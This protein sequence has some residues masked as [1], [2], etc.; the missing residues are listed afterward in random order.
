MLVLEYKVKPK[1]QQVAAI[2]EAIRTSQFVRNKVLRFW[3]DN[4]GVGKAEL[5]RY[6]TA[7]RNEFEFVKDL[8]SHAC[9]TAVERTLRAITRFYENCKQQKLGKKGY[10]KF[11]KHSRSV[12]YKVSGWKLDESTKKHITF[13]DKKGIG[14]LKLIGSRDI[15]YFQPEQIKRVRI[16]RRADGYYVQFS[17][18]LDPR[19]TVK[20][21]T[22]TQKAVGIDVGLKFFIADSQGNTEVVPQYYRKAE[23]HLNRLNRRKSNKYRK[24]KKPQSNNYH[25]ARQ[26]S[27]KKHLKVSRQREEYCKKVALRL[28]QSNDLVAYENL[29][30][31]GM[32][33]NRR[34]AKSITDAGWTTFRQWLEY[35]ADKYGKLAIAVPP[36]NTSQNCSNCGEKVQKSLS[37]RTHV[38]HHCRFVCDRDWN[39]AINIL[40]RALYIVGRTKIYA[41][42]E[43]S[44]W[45][46]GEILL[47]NE[48]SLNEESTSL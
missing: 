25:K 45:L 34:L 30:V 28:I 42:G 17:I 41:S 21:L 43:T 10:P 31:R 18:K 48:D 13:T 9:Q 38:C 29:N 6:N 8:N 33:K 15:Q 3:M 4:T 23:K 35:F 36:H 12:E 11:K 1:P 5:F 46:V 22:P 32:V 24:G 39:A 40:Q 20:P 37:T 44:S 47:A 2:E 7:L 26:R 16:V 19:D 14:K 27:A